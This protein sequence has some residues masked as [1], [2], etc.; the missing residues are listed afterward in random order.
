MQM[1]L[2]IIFALVSAAALCCAQTDAPSSSGIPAKEAPAPA[3]IIPAPASPPETNPNPPGQSAAGQST[4]SPAAQTVPTAP[5]APAG[6]QPLPPGKAAAEGRIAGAK[7]DTGRKQYVIGP[8]DV[9][10]IKVWK[11]ANL[12]GMVAVDSGGMISLQ[13]IGEIKADGL[14]ARQLKEEITQRLKECC[15]NNPEGEVSVEVVK[16]NSKHYYVYGAVLRGGEFPLDRDT[17]VM[18]ALS[19]VGGFKEFAKKK[20]IRIQRGT[21]EF[22]L[23]YEDVSRGRHLEKD[24]LLEPGDRIYVDE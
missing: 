11:D 23:N 21:K 16:N 15:V 5:P 22:L 3:P 17:T 8:Q 19:L 20:K 9:V 2:K 4:P 18:D 24:I 12:S 1:S 13:L 14:T 10:Q 6:D 7:P